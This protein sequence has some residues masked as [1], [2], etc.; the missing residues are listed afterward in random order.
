MQPSEGGKADIHGLKS[1][2]VGADGG[3]GVGGD[4]TSVSGTTGGDGRGA[5]SPPS[6]KIRKTP[7]PSPKVRTVQ[8]RVCRGIYYGC[9]RVFTRVFTRVC[10]VE[11]GL[12]P[13]YPRVYRS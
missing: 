11:L 5:A 2:G 6:V 9:T 3:G 10:P 1:S 7:P 13:G 12:V 8:E 4:T